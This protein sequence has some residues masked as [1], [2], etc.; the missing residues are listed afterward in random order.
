MFDEAQKEHFDYCCAR[1]I[2]RDFPIEKVKVSTVHF[3]CYGMGSFGL[4]RGLFETMVF[5]NR[6]D[7]VRMLAQVHYDTKL[8]A[9]QGH[10]KILEEASIWQEL[11]ED[12]HE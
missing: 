12:K 5:D 11:A 9:I 2:A 1:S 3:P 4:R 10:A 8:E 6:G 7:K